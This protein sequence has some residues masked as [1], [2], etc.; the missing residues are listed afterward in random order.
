MCFA[1]REQLKTYSFY[2]A[3]PFIA[4]AG[5][6]ERKRRRERSLFVFEFINPCGGQSSESIAMPF[7]KDTKIFLYTP[8]GQFEGRI[9]LVDK[10]S[11]ESLITKAAAPM[12][13]GA[14]R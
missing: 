10:F 7:A 11:C 14:H 12:R 8:G 1:K 4:T 5:D 2:C 3:S 9:F 6:N 13:G